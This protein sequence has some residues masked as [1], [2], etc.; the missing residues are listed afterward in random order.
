MSDELTVQGTEEVLREETQTPETDEAAVCEDVQTLLNEEQAA[1]EET[2]EEVPATVQDEDVPQEA[3]QQDPEETPEDAAAEEPEET[4][5]EEASSEGTEEI[6]EDPPVPEEEQV[7][8]DMPGEPEEAQGVPEEI[9]EETET[10]PEEEEEPEE[11]AAATEEEAPADPDYRPVESLKEFETLPEEGSG[12]Q[13]Y[14][15]EKLESAAQAPV[16]AQ[17]VPVPVQEPAK[18]RKKKGKQTETKGE[19]FSWLILPFVLVFYEIVFRQATGEVIFGRQML[20]AAA[21][22]FIYGTILFC[23][24]SLFR[25]KGI[26]RA[27][28]AVL[29]LITNLPFM[30]QYYTFRQFK[31]FYDLRTIIAGTDDVVGG[32]LGDAIK[33]VINPAGLVRLALF[34]LPFLLYVIWLRKLDPANRFRKRSLF[35]TA[36]ILILSAGLAAAVVIGVPGMRDDYRRFYNYTNAVNSYGLLTGMRLDV[37]EGKDTGSM[38]FA[39]VEAPAPTVRPVQ[40]A[41]DVPQE[42]EEE[43]P[44][45]YEPN[46][47]DIDFAALSE[48]SSEPYR[49][50]DAYVASLTPTMKNEYTGLFE[51]KNL[52]MITA[53]AFSAEV[54]DEERTPTLYRLATKGINFTDF[55]QSATAGTIGGEFQ[56]VFGMPS[57]RGGASFESMSDHYNCQTMGWQLNELGYYGI[58]FHNNDYKYYNRVVT[59]N[60]LGYSEGFYGYGNGLEEFITPTW[61]ESDLEMMEG[62]V[63]WYID[64]QPFNAYYMTVSG[65]SAYSFRWND[66]SGKNEEYVQDMPYS[67]PVRAYFA[68]NMELE[69][70]MAYLV[71]RLEEAGIADDTVIVICADHFPYGLDDDAALGNMPYL[72]ELYGYDVRNYLDRDH[73]RLIIWSGC[74]EDEDPIVVDSPVSSL[75]ILPTLS[76]LFGLEYDSRL[77]VGRDVFS[78]AEPIVFDLFYD[79]KTDLGRFLSNTGTFEPY[80]ENAEIPEGYVDR[81]KTIVNNKINYCKGVVDNDYFRHVME[82]YNAN[83]D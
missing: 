78:D 50:L 80:D 72:S 33:T 2:A 25:K 62:T 71:G 34:L 12:E 63:D 13:V 40:T 64:H 48:N 15:E 32:F 83:A 79:W 5:P 58:A 6:T 8:S 28:K 29:I 65:H 69:H 41:A 56:V 9:T 67:D 14:E 42:E 54:I 75:D 82:N 21:F 23:L 47:L 51:G 44:I 10:A 4:E 43:I 31:T 20:A 19:W 76:N 11:T 68:A 66:M 3:E 59:H 7:P 26:N 35:R 73:N 22:S 36:Y 1:A 70:A 53:E 77:Y 30:I 45:V 18:Q 16:P 37:L 52:I 24:C 17:T 55:T 74:L 57:V 60:A 81:I 38:S 27:I 61:P 39:A 49:S 46:V